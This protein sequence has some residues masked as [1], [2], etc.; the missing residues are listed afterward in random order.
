MAPQIA[1]TWLVIE[2]RQG[3]VQKTESNSQRFHS[4]SAGKGGACQ[5]GGRRQA[6]GEAE[7]MHI[8]TANLRELRRLGSSL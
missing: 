7:C 2:F 4:T 1:D 8:F 6:S 5:E 3:N